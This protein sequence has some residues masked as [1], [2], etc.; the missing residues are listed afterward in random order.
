MRYPERLTQQERS[1]QTRERLLDATIDCLVDLGYAGTSMNEICRRAG[2][3]RGA[4]QHH[5]PTK[6]ELMAHA[7]DHLTRK[8]TDQL[9]SGAASVPLGPARRSAIID[10]MWRGLSGPLA[11]AM[12]ELATAARTDPELHKALRPVE[13]SLARSTADLF[14][15]L[16]DDGTRSA[17]E[18]DTLFWLTLTFVR[19]LAVDEVLGG[20]PKR[21]AHLLE[22]WKVLMGGYQDAG[23]SANSA[24]APSGMAGT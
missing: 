21:R 15:G 6:A 14:R 9:V 16:V 13:R 2:L 24:A 8:L 7:V 4:Q 1:E 20:D 18:L 10:L 17:E 22:E 11:T 23:S 3:S 19:G 5:F 12:Q